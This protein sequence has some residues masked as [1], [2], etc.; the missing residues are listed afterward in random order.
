MVFQFEHIT[1]GYHPQ[2]GKWQPQ[3]F[4]LIKLKQVFNKWQTALVDS[5]WNSLFWN[6]HDLPR[7]VS[8]YGDPGRFR[9]E[10]AKMLAT[11]LHFMQGTPYIYQGEEIGMTNVRFPKIED[12]QD[13]ESLNL[14]AERTEAGVPVEEMM[15]GIY[16]NGRDN[17]RTPMQWSNEANGGFSRVSPWLKVN[18][19]YTE[20][21]VEAAL[22][23]P[24]SI[25][26]HYQKLIALRKNKPIIT[27]GKYQ[28]LL[29]AH[30]EVFAYLR[31]LDNEHIVVISN[32]CGHQVQL[33]LPAEI[34]NIEG[35]WLI[36][37]YPPR[38]GLAEEITLQP[39]ESFAIS[40]LNN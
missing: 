17:A 2:H 7:I 33:P 16:T 11:T 21:N 9:V 25:F 39:Y 35:E 10:S 30:K 24:D 19:N 27:W 31:I 28:Q 6:N 8:K 5:G 14:Y 20:I 3:P 18:P 38:H 37:N 29:E 23:D 13:I 34:R 36:G 26:F 4:D 40:W 32:F 15:E 22:N 12:Y 1:I